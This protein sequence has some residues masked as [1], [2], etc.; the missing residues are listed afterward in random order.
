MQDQ[1]NTHLMHTRLEKQLHETRTLSKIQRALSEGEKIGLENLLQLIVN[2]AGELIPNANRVVL[3]LLDE[4]NQVLIP[5][6]L[7]GTGITTPAS[8]KIPWGQGIAG[9]AIAEGRTISVPDIQSEAGFIASPNPTT[10]RAIIAVPIT[11][12]E[13]RPIGVISIT[14]DQPGAFT[15]DDER[16]LHTLSLHAAI[17]LE[18]ARLLETTRQNLKEISALY[19]ISRSLANSLDLDELLRD[20]TQGLHQIF[21]FYYVQVLIRDFETDDLVL[22]HASGEPAQEMM[23]QGNRTL[24]GSGIIGYVAEFGEPV[25][26]NDVDAVVFFLRNPLL[27]DTK[28]ELTVPI[29]VNGKVL[30][31]LDIQEK[32]PRQFTRRQEK[33]MSAVAEQLSVAV[34]K[35]LLYRDLQNALEQEKETRAQLLQSQRLSETG[36]LLASIS[37]ELNNPLQSIQN[38]LFLIKQDPQ[39]SEQSK[40]DLEIILSETERMSTLLGR[41]RATYHVAQKDEF[42]PTSIHTLI[43]DVLALTNTYM[44]H[45]NIRFEFYPDPYLPIFPAIPDK[46]RQVM[47]NLFMN[48]IEAMEENGVLTVRTAYN[49]TEE[50]IYITV[51]DTGPG[52]PPALLPRI[53]EPFVTSKAKGTGLG[54]TIC[55]DIIQQHHGQISAENNPNGGA[56]FKIWLPVNLMT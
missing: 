47:L 51:S 22:R 7:T 13:N 20:V 37:H 40:Q 27:P 8:L 31:V 5:R 28:S 12:S 9:H 53:F 11:N 54:L 10:S 16:L 15:P 3:H 49:E 38:A 56:T 26:T 23:K 52:I 44:R 36:R 4:E 6:A 43:E 32:P 17:A 18:N 42:Q 1:E 50:R 21:G 14:S 45:R 29:K 24:A 35:A 55:Y 34:Q 39:L 48:A 41:L 46:I 33:L 19:H 2:A 30:G 25:F